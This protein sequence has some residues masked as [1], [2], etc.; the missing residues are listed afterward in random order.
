[1]VPKI[2]IVTFP[3]TYNMGNQKISSQHK[4][5]SHKNSIH[6]TIQSTNSIHL[7]QNKSLFALSWYEP[8]T[9]HKI[10]FVE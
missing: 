6:N 5:I 10:L 7:I 8:K 1:M 3:S 4:R 9:N 2:P